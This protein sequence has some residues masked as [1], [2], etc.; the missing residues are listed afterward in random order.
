MPKK[1]DDI[2]KRLGELENRQNMFF[3]GFTL[4]TSYVDPNTGKT[5]P[6]PTVPNMGQSNLTTTYN[7]PKT[8]LTSEVQNNTT[9]TN[10]AN[11]G[12]TGVQLAAAQSD[13]AMLAS[14]AN[15]FGPKA[16]M[17]LNNDGKKQTPIIQ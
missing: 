3:G 6:M 2:E 11:A 1:T 13:D 4:P 9:N 12:L 5:M 17:D 16:T 7:H 10:P 14:Q 15:V 8:R